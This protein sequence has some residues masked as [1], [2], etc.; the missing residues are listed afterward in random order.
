[1]HM[2]M[3]INTIAS[4]RIHP[5]SPMRK[6]TPVPARYRLA[7][8]SRCLAASVGGYALVS[9][10][11]ALLAALLAT[12]GAAAPA[13]AAVGA[14]MFGLVA[15]VVAALWVFACRSTIRAW[16]GIGACTLLFA[17]ADL[18]CYRLGAA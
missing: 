12:F 9:A 17:L 10:G 14:M 3:F 16:L 18:A 13:Q 7:V 11:S 15:Y 2:R 6:P 4:F 8:L 1:M 5:Y